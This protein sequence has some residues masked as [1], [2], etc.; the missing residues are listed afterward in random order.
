MSAELFIIFVS[1]ISVGTIYHLPTTVWVFYHKS[2]SVLLLVG[3]ISA[4]LAFSFCDVT[5]GGDSDEADRQKAP[6]LCC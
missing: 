5:A 2:S 1:L 3:K 4:L 6:Y